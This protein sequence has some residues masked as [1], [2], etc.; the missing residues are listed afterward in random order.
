ME[1]FIKGKTYRVYTALYTLYSDASF[2]F[3]FELLHHALHFILSFRSRVP[4]V[5]CT[6]ASC[7]LI[8]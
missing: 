8:K 5:W 7:Q 4:N 2:H 3:I 1:Q 6:K